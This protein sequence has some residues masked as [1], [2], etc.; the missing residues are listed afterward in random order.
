M[1][2]ID[3]ASSVHKHK[4]RFRQSKPVTRSSQHFVEL[5]SSDYANAVNNQLN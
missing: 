2:T 4:A 5:N 3:E 1:L